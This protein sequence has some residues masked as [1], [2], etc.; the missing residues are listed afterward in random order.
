MSQPHLIAQIVEEVGLKKGETRSLPALSSRILKRDEHEPS[1]NCPFNYRKVIGKLNFLEKSSRPDIA[2]ATHQ[3]ARFSIDPKESHVKAVIHL[4]K[5]L[6][7]TANEGIILDPREDKSFEVYADA[8]FAGNWNPT[9]AMDDPSTAKSRTGFVIT[10]AAC[11]IL[12]SS[13]L[14]TC[15]SLS[16]T[17][18]EYV[19]LSQCL[20][21]TI[22][23]M[24]LLQELKD[25]GFCQANATPVV[26]CKAFEDNS[27]ALELSLVPK[28]RPRTKHINNVYHHF[29]KFVRDKLISVTKI[30]TEDQ[31]ADMFT[32]PLTLD[33]FVKH[34]KSLLGF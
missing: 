13:K 12:W 7:S 15:I 9:T 18:A 33:L 5:Y 31:V 21:D 32:K 26:H 8:D 2:Y 27:G 24:Q 3:C 19:A 16:T 29:R 1:Y 34:R 10:Y 22:P 28:L 11:P 30:G 4:A 6:Q 25:K 20:F 14:Q 17:E 23:I